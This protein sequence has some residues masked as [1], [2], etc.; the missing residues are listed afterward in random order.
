[1][2]ARKPASSPAN[3]HRRMRQWLLMFVCVTLV[4]TR[5]DGAHLHLCLD[6]QAPSTSVRVA[7]D[8][9]SE[10]GAQAPHNDRDLALTG[11]LI[12]KQ[13]KG[14]LKQPVAIPTGRVAF[15]IAAAR[16]ERPLIRALGIASVSF[17][18]LPPVRGPPIRITA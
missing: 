7:A 1:M 13:G 18:S 5:A 17:V 6:G 12:A 10:P 15:L 2:S 4:A 14:D 16:F 11:D 9:S 8:L 3:T